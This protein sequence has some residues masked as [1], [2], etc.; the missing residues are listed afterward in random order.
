MRHRR[1]TPWNTHASSV[2]VYLSKE[3]EVRTQ[4]TIDSNPSG[5][6]GDETE[7]ETR[8]FVEHEYVITVLY[9]PLIPGKLHGPPEDC[10]PD[11]GDEVEDILSVTL[12]GTSLPSS[13]WPDFDYGDLRDIIHEQEPEDDYDGYD[14]R[15]REAYA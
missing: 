10:Y 6:F 4:T 12:N 9:L 7:V 1:R 14:D 13:A 8:R 11:E 15:E 3:V 5:W 2:T